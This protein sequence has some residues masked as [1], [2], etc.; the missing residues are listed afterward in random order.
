MPQIAGATDSDISAILLRNHEAKGI[1]FKLC[2]KVTSVRDGTVTYESGGQVA[3]LDA[4]LILVAVGRRPKTDAV[5][6]EN[7]GVRTNRGAILTDDACRTSVPGVF[8]AGD[9]NGK[10]MLAH[11]AYREG[12]VAINVMTGL[13]DTVDYNAIP[14]V[15]IYKS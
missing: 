1:T 13:R 15:S 10:S 12:E 6:L 3:T 14:A 5:G 7:I 9:C 2:A 4:D 11:T 8:A